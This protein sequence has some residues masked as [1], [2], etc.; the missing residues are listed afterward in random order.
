MSIELGQEI[1]AV[2]RSEAAS[3]GMDVD[4][5]IV[6]V[7]RAYL[8]GLSHMETD[9][10]ESLWASGIAREWTEDLADQRQDIYTLADGQPV[11]APG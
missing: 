10:A 7:V 5:L 8:D 1:E 11:N 6:A 2:L 4:A 3:R 9:P